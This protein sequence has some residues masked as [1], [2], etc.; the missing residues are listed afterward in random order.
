MAVAERNDG[1]EGS[2]G[3]RDLV[4]DGFGQEAMFAV[5]FR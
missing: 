3:E 5:G 4:C 2:N 1:V